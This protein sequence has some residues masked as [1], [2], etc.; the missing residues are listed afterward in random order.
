MKQH[1]EPKPKRN[2]AGGL[3]IP[4][5]SIGA[6]YRTRHTSGSLT[7]PKDVRVTLR[8]TPPSQAKMSF[9]HIY[10]QRIESPELA[11]KDQHD[12]LK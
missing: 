8:L 11:R 10:P 4:L 5:S 3:L 1:T 2:P 7:K 9:E 12:A 6:A